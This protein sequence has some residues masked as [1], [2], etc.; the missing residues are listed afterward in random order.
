MNI[1]TRNSKR[2][3][4]AR[5]T[6]TTVTGTPTRPRLRVFRSLRSLSAQVIDDTTH[7]TLV[8]AHLA[9]IAGATNTVDG[10]A[11][12]GTLIAKKAQ[13]KKITTVVFDRAGYKYHGK[14]KALAEAARAA[15]LQF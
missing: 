14:V 7:A 5:R 1:M 3:H 15:G 2:L 8:S 9:E 11:Q 10:A 12:L 6:R 13:D 4:R